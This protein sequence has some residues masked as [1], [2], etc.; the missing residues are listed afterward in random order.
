MF[1]KSKINEPGP[2]E[3]TTPSAAPAAPAPS[4]PSGPMATST[5]AAPAKPKPPASLLSSDLVITGNLK[6]SGDIQIEG[7]VKGDIRAHSLTV[8]ESAR[9]D[10]EILPDDVVV[11]GYV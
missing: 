2:K 1:S 11:H 6:T 7:T 4:A 8:G 9:I 3:T 5:S 10:G